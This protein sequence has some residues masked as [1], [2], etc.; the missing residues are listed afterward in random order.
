V[1][2]PIPTFYIYDHPTDYPATVGHL[3][4]M[5][6]EARKLIPAG[7]VAMGDPDPNVVEVWMPRAMA[8]LMAHAV[9]P[10]GTPFVVHRGERVSVEQVVNP[11]MKH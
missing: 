9:V 4:E 6:D 5:L 8:D 11:R 2:N 7:M 1:T 3:A 10:S